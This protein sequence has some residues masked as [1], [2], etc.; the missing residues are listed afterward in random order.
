ML[1][2]VILAPLS[3]PAQRRI[4][5]VPFRRVNAYM[6]VDTGANKTILNAR[7]IG[8]V[9]HQASQ[10]VNQ[11]AGIIGNAVRLRVDV[12]IAHHFLFSQPVSVMNLAD[13]SKR[14]QIPFDGLLGQDIL[15]QLRSVR[16]DYK[17]HVIEL[18]P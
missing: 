12:E 1:F 9:Q 5:S 4:V 10:P 15:S 7:S 6:L 3:L 17:A 8:R 14:F 2:L 11:G 13:L 16:I 18:E